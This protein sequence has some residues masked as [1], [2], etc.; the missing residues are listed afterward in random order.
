MIAELNKDEVLNYCDKYSNE[1]SDLAKQ[2]IKQT[3]ENES[4]PQMISGLQV[5][6][7]LQS[8]IIAIN[9]KSILEIG[10]FT[11]YSALKMS[12]CL[13]PDAQIH[14][15]EISKNHIKTAQKIFDLSKN[16]HQINI[17]EGPALDSLK[18]FKNNSF[19]FCF[20]DADKNNYVNYYKKCINLLRPN[21]VMIL[22]NML[23]GGK[24][25]KPKD[26]ETKMIVETAKIINEDDKCFNTM[27]TIRD[28]LMLCIK[29]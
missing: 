18:S 26:K 24:V 28:G 23:W 22:D 8:F 14:T 1:D 15:C 7:I 27:L 21:G 9:A 12:E 19:D 13:A 5:G 6:N 17:H 3:F 20:V 16:G 10:M 25:L 29:K 11:G 4:A 2:L